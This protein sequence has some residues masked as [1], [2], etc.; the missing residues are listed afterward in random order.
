MRS[1]SMTNSARMWSAI[2]YPMH[3]LVQQ[4]MT[5]AR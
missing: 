5:V 2:A 1:A 3:S 4:S